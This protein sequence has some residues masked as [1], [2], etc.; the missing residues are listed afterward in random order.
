[1]SSSD[2]RRVL[3]RATVTDPGDEIVLSGIAGRFPNSDNMSELAENL[4]NK[5]DLVDD[6]E[7]RWRHLNP[8]IPKRSGKVR[9]IDKFDSFFFSVHRRQAGIS[10]PQ[11]RILL[12][13]AYE[14]ILD[15]G[16]NPKS[17]RETRTGVFVGCSIAETEEVFYSGN[18]PKDGGL[19]LTG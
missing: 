1:M 3:T 16:V 7:R 19:A 8:E 6:D 15:A 18:A 17:L 2:N 14:A 13:H 5:V 12:E 9:H 4:Y 10:D 11:C